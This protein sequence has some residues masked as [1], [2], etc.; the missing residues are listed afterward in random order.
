MKITTSI[1]F[2]ALLA[3]TIAACDNEP[4][5]YFVEKIVVQGS[6]YTGHA[7][8]IDLTKSVRWNQYYDTNA[9]RLSEADVRIR[10]NEGTEY[11]LTETNSGVEGTYKAPPDAPLVEKG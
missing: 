3:L 10:V 5:D 1:L 2:F 6:M 8:S 4:E 9:V 7:M 11:L